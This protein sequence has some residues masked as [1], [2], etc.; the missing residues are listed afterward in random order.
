M[1]GGYHETLEM[2]L[3]SAY[4]QEDE[5]NHEYE[6]EAFLGGLLKGAGSLLGLGEGEDE[7]ESA[8]AHEYETEDELSGEYEDEAFLG[9]LLKGVG[10]AL[11]LGE[12]EDEYESAYAHEYEDESYA[13]EH[14]DEQFLGGLLKGAG[15]LLGLGE[16]EDEYE[17]AY[18]HEYEFEY[19]DEQFFGKALR[20]IGRFVKKAAPMLKSIAK[21]AAPM[22][23]GAIGG[24]A[25]AMLAKKATSL[26][27]EGEYEFE[28]E[29]ELGEGEFE[30]EAAGPIAHHEALAEYMAA[31]AAE[32][33]SEMEAEALVGA[34]TASVLTAR[35]RRSLRKLQRSLVKGSAALTRLLRRRRATRPL[36][37][38][39][40]TIV[41]RTARICSHRAAQGRPVTSK[42]VARVMSNQTR[43]V[44]TNPRAGQAALV[45]NVR[46]TRA[47][48][49]S[50]G[51][52][53]A[54]V[55]RP[56]TRQPYSRVR[57]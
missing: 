3:E 50:G 56:A 7:D 36:V 10:S 55:G 30:M 52:S 2:G 42:T 46:A 23:A 47:I 9:G 45:R 14:E 43:R 12:G 44:L 15:S 29:F 24:P 5:M 17:S 34:A 39:I 21:V 28:Q 13:H 18:A 38:A 32:A 26:L 22:V 25:A 53:V 19:E 37:R 6:D 33:S 31:A 41:R 20:G 4:E 51:G 1:A 40:P 49:R 54:G 57:R 48:A 35:D 8:Y 27:R 11:G 16:G